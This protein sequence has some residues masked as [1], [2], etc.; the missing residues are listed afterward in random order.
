[1]IFRGVWCPSWAFWSH[2]TLTNDIVLLQLTKPV[3][4]SRKIQ[5][6]KINLGHTVA[7]TPAW[8]GGWG[9]DGKHPTTTLQLTQV[10]IMED[11]YR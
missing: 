8:V 7:H 10:K 1:M 5:P 3:P 11:D 6:I 4:L 2:T 9:L